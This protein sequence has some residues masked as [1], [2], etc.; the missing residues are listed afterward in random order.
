ME[1]NADDDLPVGQLAARIHDEN[2]CESI[3]QADV[4]RG[5]NSKTGEHAG[6]FWGAAPLRRIMRKNKSE[7]LRLF[8]VPI[9][10]ETDDI[11]V[12]IAL[13]VYIK[14]ACC[15]E[16]CRNNPLKPN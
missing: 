14:G 8:Q 1:F 13:T 9:D 12:M 2:F 15:W 11:E 16:T 3:R 4:V 6:V 10:P 5:I 7:M